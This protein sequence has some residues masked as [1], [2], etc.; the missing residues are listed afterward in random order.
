MSQART[1]PVHWRN[2]TLALILDIIVAALIVGMINDPDS[3]WRLS[4]VVIALWVVPWIFRIKAGIYFLINYRLNEHT[5]V[6]EQL[7]RE[8]TDKGYP[9][10]SEQ[11]DLAQDYF[12]EVATDAAA[13]I[14]ARISA[15]R[16]LGADA[17]WGQ[18]Q[19]MLTRWLFNR[20]ALQ[21]IASYR[22]RCLSDRKSTRLNSSH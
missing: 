9:C 14:E 18:T 13:G 21:V 2:A 8:L 6:V 3:F 10:P 7:S 1:V 16:Y 15:A 17:A 20:A 5:Q 11:Y 4:T 22:S 12:A 19:Q